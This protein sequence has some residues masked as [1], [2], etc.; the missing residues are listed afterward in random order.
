[1]G[2]WQKIRRKTFEIGQVHDL[3]R[4]VEN[5]NSFLVHPV[6]HKFNFRSAHCV[7]WDYPELS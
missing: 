3:S 5:G 1:M 6:L 7:I 4:P 2:G